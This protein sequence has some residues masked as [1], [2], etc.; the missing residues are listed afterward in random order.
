MCMPTPVVSLESA[1]VFWD[2]VSE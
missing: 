1:Q 2:I